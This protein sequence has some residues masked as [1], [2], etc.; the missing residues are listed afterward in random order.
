MTRFTVRGSPVVQKCWLNFLS[1]RMQL[2]VISWRIFGAKELKM[3]LIA[4]D[5]VFRKFDN[6]PN[7]KG[8]S[9]HLAKITIYNSHPTNSHARLSLTALSLNSTSFALLS[10]DA[11]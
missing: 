8:L 2:V 1:F 5:V 6:V 10:Q 4:R 7:P 9:K 3:T 11:S